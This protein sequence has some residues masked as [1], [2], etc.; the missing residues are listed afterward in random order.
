MLSPMQ[1]MVLEKQ[2]SNPS[3]APNAPKIGVEHQMA[4]A[5]NA[6]MK[7]LKGI[8]STQ[9]KAELKT[10]LLAK[11]KDYVETL[12]EADQGGDDNIVAQCMV[13]AIDAGQIEPSWMPWAF[14]VANYAIRHNIAPAR[15]FNR[16]AAPF[17]LE[18][19][20][21]QAETARKSQAPFEKSWLTTALELTE[22]ADMHDQI[23]AKAQKELGLML[24][25]A[26]NASAADLELAIA[27][28]EAA[29]KIDSKIGV[30]GE[31]KK[32]R[33]LLKKAQE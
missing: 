18:T 14:K 25:S 28:L 1:K 8:K 26:A 20:A 4:V 24:S 27:C 10:T 9:T 30:A 33:A 17:L 3:S 15:G 7:A 21:E 31:L 22:G 6:D 16:A 12:I 13:W 23:R 5:L 29:V 2:A 32:A 11:Y 19:I